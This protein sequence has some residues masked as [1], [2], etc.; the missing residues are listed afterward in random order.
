MP[1]RQETSKLAWQLLLK[2]KYPNALDLSSA[3]LGIYQVLLW[4]EQ[5]HEAGFS[6]LPHII[7]ADKLRRPPSKRKAAGPTKPNAWQ[8]RASAAEEYLARELNVKTEG[9]PALVD[10]L[11][12]HPNYKGMQRQNP[13]G[14]AFVSLVARILAKYSS[15]QL[16][17]K[18][19][20]KATSAFPGFTIPGR[21]TTPSIDILVRKNSVPRAVISVK[22]SLRHDRV[23][24]C[25]QRVRP[26]SHQQAAC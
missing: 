14:M 23:C 4:Y 20:V 12:R 18:E 21:S 26:I 16:S 6:Q 8:L 11:M 19:E 10:R 5:I 24:R 2:S 22:W 25:D 1:T 15:K 3:W 9:V 7:D 13:L 17:F